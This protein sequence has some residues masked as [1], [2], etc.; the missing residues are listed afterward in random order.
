M[1]LWQRSFQ[2]SRALFCSFEYALSLTGKPF[3]ED[4]RG[5]LEFP[6]YES[7]T[8]YFDYFLR[9]FETISASPQFKISRSARTNVPGAK[10][11]DFVIIR[12][13]SERDASGNWFFMS[14]VVL[15]VVEIKPLSGHVSP[16]DNE[17]QVELAL[18]RALSAGK[19]QA[20]SQ[21]KY[22]FA[23][24]DQNVV[25]AI[26]GAG[27]YWR[28]DIYERDSTSPIQRP[29]ETQEQYVTNNRLIKD[30]PFVSPLEKLG[31]KK[32]ALQFIDMLV[33]MKKKFSISDGDW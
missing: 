5:G 19:K 33:E 27:P 6:H 7:Y 1:T 18:E 14:R 11:P 21:A 30:A 23:S 8:L 17:K 26:H 32:S 4:V 2:I 16:K 15:A 22:I 31:T 29:N 24:R 13:L 20:K 3:N 25:F 12:S 28:Y 9:F 10:W